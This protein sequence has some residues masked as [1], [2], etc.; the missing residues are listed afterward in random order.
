[1]ER[2]TLE[3]W[4]TVFYNV[5]NDDDDEYVEV[6]WLDSTDEWC[7]NVG[8]E[9]LEDGFTSEQKAQERLDYVTRKCS[10]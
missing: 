6:T 7:I 8:S 4:E 10:T 2:L 9:L 1:M 3:E 5:A